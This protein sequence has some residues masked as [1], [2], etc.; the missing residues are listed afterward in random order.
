M[1]ADTN[2][3]SQALSGSGIKQRLFI[4]GPTPIPD[5]VQ[6]AMSGPIVY[7]RGPEFPNLLK[8]VVED[9]KRL[10][11]TD[12][13]L[14]LLSSS[15]TGAMEAAI[16]NTLSPGDRVVVAQAGSFGARW[17]DICAAY[18]IDVVS[19]DAEWGQSIDPARIEAALREDAR[20]KAVL[21][22][23][24]ETSTGALHDIEGIGRAMSTH[25]A[26]LVV[27]GVSSVCAHP[28]DTSAFC[29]DVAMTGSQKGLGLPPGLA[30]L[31]FSDRAREASQKAKCPRFYLD[32][33]TYRDALV[34]GR[35]PSTLPVTLISGM[36]A[37]LDMVHED[38]IEAVW[39]RHAIHARAVREA[40]WSIGLECF[41][42][43]SGNVLTAVSLPES[44]DGLELMAKLRQSYGIVIGG[45]LAHLR[46][47]IIRISN[48][49]FVT[50]ADIRFV[51][52]ALEETLAWMGLRFDRGAAV[53]AAE[54]VLSS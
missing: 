8:S 48:L 1:L 33:A 41:A 26:L 42:A 28:L 27:D 45:G 32:L 49:G 29:V 23:H 16:V 17:K 13:E 47:R 20:I 22:T 19:V 4:P 6:K 43:S 3:P 39:S 37:A 51:V 7:H 12:D 46:G 21:T 34:E 30:V 54:K 24:S 14:F 36:R 40:V 10:F 2:G 44:I 5:R 18:D 15:G 35:G 50:D 9:A 11:P 25:D 53:G 38:G 31:T 52:K